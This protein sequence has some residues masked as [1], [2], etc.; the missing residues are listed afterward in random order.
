MWI[1]HPFTCPA[2]AGR[3]SRA[4]GVLE[5]RVGGEARPAGV[6]VFCGIERPL[7]V[8]AI[9]EVMERVK[10]TV[11]SLDNRRAHPR[12]EVSLPAELNAGGRTIFCRTTNIS[13]GGLQVETL[14]RSRVR[15]GLEALFR[16]RNCGEILARIFLGERKVWEFKTKLAYVERFRFHQP[17]QVGL[18]FTDL[19]EG[20]DAELKSFLA[21]A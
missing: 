7:R 13:A 14:T 8:K 12:R 11:T 10:N 21:T 9:A 15:K 20:L 1:Q 5:P 19:D 2:S 6:D 4:C 17:E 18:S 3:A 16:N